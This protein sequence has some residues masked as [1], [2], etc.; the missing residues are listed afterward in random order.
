MQSMYP[1]SLYLI[2]RNFYS[3]NYVS[4][5]NLHKGED[6]VVHLNIG[7]GA[8]NIFKQYDPLSVLR[9][10]ILIMRICSYAYGPQGV[11]H[12]LSMW[13]L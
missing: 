11:D 7:M 6:G 8:R 9:L 13:Y 1:D 2:L 12:V 5:Q 10:P 3:Y 4:G